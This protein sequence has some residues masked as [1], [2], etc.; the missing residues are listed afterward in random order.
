MTTFVLAPPK[1]DEAFEFYS[2]YIRLVPS[3][4]L[5]ETAAHQVDEL[6]NL[7]KS[8]NEVT[9]SI[10]HPPY[11]WTIKQV[12]GHMIDTERIFANRLHRFACGD[13]QPLP[14]M[15]QEPYVT[16]C[17]YD[18]PNIEALIEELCCLRRAN[19]CLMRRLKP[20]QWDHRG[21]ASGHPV[22]VRALGYMLVG[23]VTY[24]LQI[25]KKRIHT[26]H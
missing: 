12:I 18:S 7:L 6:T 4:D 5:L 2:T 17:D 1:S 19:I 16:N 15:E 21:I 26:D 22:T 13:L 11:T 8:L 20:N 9:A 24:H 3:G 14:G 10:I 23:H 25:I